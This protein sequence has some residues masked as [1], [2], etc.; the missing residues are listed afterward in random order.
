[1]DTVFLLFQ[2]YLINLLVYYIYIKIF[3]KILLGPQVNS[4]ELNSILD[5][6]FELHHIP[7]C[8]NGVLEDDQNREFFS[9]HSNG[10]NDWT[11][12]K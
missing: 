10:K 3:A 9:Y 12:A 2:L 8:S 1:M 6:K 11:M 5:N 7:K 4:Y